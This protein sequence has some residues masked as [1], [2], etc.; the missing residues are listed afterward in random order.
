MK[1]FKLMVLPA[2][3]CGGLAL[4]ACGGNYYGGADVGVGAVG[5]VA[6]DDC[7]GFYDDFYGPF[8]DGCWGNDGYFWYRGGDHGW[9]RD[10]ARHFSHAAGEHM[11]PIAGHGPG[12]G[13]HFGGGRPGGAHTGGGDRR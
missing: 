2:A 6:L 9:H 7:S 11:H 10:D 12:A 5:P 4:S 13:A 3:F 1:L 8:D